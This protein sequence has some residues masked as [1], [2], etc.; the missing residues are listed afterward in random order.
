[1]LNILVKKGWTQTRIAR[2]LG[3]TASAVC[4]AV[5]KL[6]GESEKSKG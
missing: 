4:Q 2:E 1:M 6:E 5:K 3:V